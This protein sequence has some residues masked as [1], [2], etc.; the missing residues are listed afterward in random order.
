MCARCSAGE[1]PAR[2]KLT[3]TLLS[4]NRNEIY[5]IAQTHSQVSC[6]GA[7]QYRRNAILISIG[8]VYGYRNC[9]PEI[10][11]GDPA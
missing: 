10:P 8:E 5:Y 1:H 4:T 11:G 2:C 9:F 3:V 7:V 6:A